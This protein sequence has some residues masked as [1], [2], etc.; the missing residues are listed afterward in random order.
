MTRGENL[1]TVIVFEVRRTLL[2]PSFWL[3][4]L[5]IPL[6]M[7]FVFGLVF[8]SQS[9]AESGADAARS[10]PIAFTYTDASGLVSPAVAERLGGTPTPDAAGAAQAVREGRAALHID[11]PATPATEPVRLVC[12]EADGVLTSG[13]YHSIARDLVQQSVSERIGDPALVD[14]V[15]DVQTDAEMWSDGQRSYGVGSAIAPG[16]FLVLM[17]MAIF[18][19]GNQM[20]T[21][22]VEEKE[23]RV[24]EMIL[25]T[26]R[27]SSLIIGKVI[28]VVIVGVIQ[29]LVFLAPLV[30]ATFLIP[31]LARGAGVGTAAGLR[32]AGEPVV[33]ELAPVLL[34]AGWFLGGFLLFTGLLVTIGAIMPTAKEAGSA[35]GVVILAMFLPLYAMA[36]V[37]ADPEGVVS[38]VLTWIPLTAPTTAL[39]RNATGSLSLAEGLGSLALTLLTASL[40]LWW[41]VRLFG[42]GSIQYEGR[43]K[44]LNFSRRRPS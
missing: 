41:G 44:V 37:V 4:S 1:G 20:L 31:G 10:E 28:A 30:L 3:T 27:P 35:F 16:V 7:A 42:R 36:A 23:N 29:G 43:L 40:L 33:L 21:I 6:L 5:S 11:V 8:L 12:A 39:V 18:L 34:G 22:T 25:T 17:F 13:R 24:T 9:A 15:R 32:V 26:I 14:L 38:R 19:L 2:K